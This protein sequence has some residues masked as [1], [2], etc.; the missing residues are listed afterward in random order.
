ML[1]LIHQNR[2]QK[3]S[4]HTYWVEKVDPNTDAPE[5]QTS[6]GKPYYN[7]VAIVPDVGPVAI[8]AYDSENDACAI[9]AHMVE[10]DL[11]CGLVV[12][13]R[14]DEKEIKEFL[15]SS[16]GRGLLRVQ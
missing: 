5:G 12:M 2:T 8:A 6:E 10:I 14:D 11:E 1:D 15:A 13:P 7:I 4:A 9:F 3:I 16:D